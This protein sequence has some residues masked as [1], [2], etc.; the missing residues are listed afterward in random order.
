ML[1]QKLKLPAL[2]S[3]DL[4]E[5]YDEMELIGCVVSVPA[6]E[7]ARSKYRGEVLAADY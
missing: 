1:Y 4:E 5:L 7:L 6:F 2:K 3:S